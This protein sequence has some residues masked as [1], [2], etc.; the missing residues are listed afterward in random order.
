MANTYYSAF[1]VLKSYIK[2]QELTIV[3]YTVKQRYTHCTMW[4]APNEGNI[5]HFVCDKVSPTQFIIYW[6]GEDY[7]QLGQTSFDFVD[8]NTPD[9][10]D[11]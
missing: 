5:T 3:N 6:Y 10:H 4:V 11:C 1:D 7:A 2:S 8:V 9:L